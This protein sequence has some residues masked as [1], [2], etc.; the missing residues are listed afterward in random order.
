MIA[1]CRNCWKL[2]LAYKATKDN[3]WSIKLFTGSQLMRSSF[4]C[5][6]Q[7][8]IAIQ[9]NRNFSSGSLPRPQAAKRIC[10]TLLSTDISN[11]KYP[12]KTH[13]YNA[14]WQSLHTIPMKMWHACTVVPCHILFKAIL[15][16]QAKFKSTVTP[17]MF[18]KIRNYVKN[19]QQEH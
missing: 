15:P 13:K 5:L 2:Y 11:N 8:G 14:T 6:L 3:C 1:L 19:K 9:L 10:Y 18:C 16:L 4:V 17:K 12:L 7:P